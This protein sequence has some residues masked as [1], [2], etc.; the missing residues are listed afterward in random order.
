[1]TSI[2]ATYTLP[3]ILLKLSLVSLKLFVLIV[4][5]VELGVVEDEGS[6]WRRKGIARE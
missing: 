1:M 4:T 3:K 2:V 5:V 6:D